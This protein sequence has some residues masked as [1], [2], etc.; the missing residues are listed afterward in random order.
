MDIKS[1]TTL[2]PGVN[3]RNLLSLSLMLWEN[4][5]ECFFWPVIYLDVRL[6]RKY[7]VGAKHSSLF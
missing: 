6:D 5:L 3:V 1:F 2:A 7:I 4:K